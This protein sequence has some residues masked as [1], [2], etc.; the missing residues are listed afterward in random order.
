MLYQEMCNV[1]QV[2]TIWDLAERSTRRMKMSNPSISI[3]IPVWN[4]KELFE[5]TLNNIKAQEYTDW[6]CIAIDDGST[7]GTKEMISAMAA[8]DSRIRL[9]EKDPNRP[10]GPSAS[11]NIG[12]ELAKGRYVHYFDSDDLLKEDFYRFAT[13]KLEDGNLDFFATGIRW[14]IDGIGE[15]EEWYPLESEPFVR[16]NFA[17]R[18]VATKHRIWTQ[19]VIWRRSLL[20]NLESG[21]RE[22]LT[23]VEDLEYSVRAMLAAA[24]F[25]F[26]SEPRVFIRRHMESLTFKEDLGRDLERRL[27]IDEVFWLILGEL[28]KHSESPSWAVYYCLF[29]RYK[30]ITWAVRLGLFD[31]RL[32]TRFPRLFKDLLLR[33]K[34]LALRI[35]LRIPVF[36]LMGVFAYFRRAFRFPKAEASA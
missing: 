19:N 7:D 8:S 33:Q 28:D 14:F 32:L 12:F 18:A 26:D 4:R 22:D 24:R 20:A 17:A 25:D 34:D 35:A 27:S 3:I 6:E 36:F 30:H 2:D 5:Q 11:R 13:E 29:Q 9:V 10:K 15:K 1:V 23:Q 16:D 21:Y 31:R